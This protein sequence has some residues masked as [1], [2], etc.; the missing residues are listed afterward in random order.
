MK[1]LITLLF[2]ITLLSSAALSAQ[3][4]DATQA[5]ATADVATYQASIMAFGVSAE[6]A[7]IAAQAALD[8]I[9][10]QHAPLAE[11]VESPP[12]LST[13]WLS[14]PYLIRD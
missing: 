3:D 11:K 2:S 4:K 14:N 13:S 12:T 1:P 9:A 8:A 7:A 5:P 10:E 6:Q